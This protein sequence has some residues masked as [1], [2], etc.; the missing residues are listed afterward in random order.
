M[1]TSDLEEQVNKEVEEIQRMQ[2]YKIIIESYQ[3][4]LTG[5]M[6]IRRI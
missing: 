3:A 1:F 2:N 5:K 4:N 6:S